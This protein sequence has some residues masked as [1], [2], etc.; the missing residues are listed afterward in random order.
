MKWST[1]LGGRAKNTCSKGAEGEPVTSEVSMSAGSSMDF[2][3]STTATGGCLAPEAAAARARGSP[4]R[5]A[6]VG[7]KCMKHAVAAR[8]LSQSRSGIGH[9]NLVHDL[10]L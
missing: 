9:V 1:V 4:V 6:P 5:A 10:S 3:G 7:G 2:C 8:V